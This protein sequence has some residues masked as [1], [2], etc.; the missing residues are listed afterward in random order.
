MRTKTNWLTVLPAENTRIIAGKWGS[1]GEGTSVSTRTRF[2]ETT[3]L[4]SLHLSP[5]LDTMPVRVL[6][7]CGFTQ[8]S[9]IYSKQVCITVILPDPAGVV[10]TNPFSFPSSARSARHV[11]TPSSSSSSLL[12]SSRRRT[13]HGPRLP[14]TSLRPTLPPRP[15]SKP[16]RQLR[17]LGGLLAATRAST[18]VSMPRYTVY[19]V[20]LTCTGFDET[21]TYIHDFMV[22]NGP[23]DGIMGFSQGACMASILAALVGYM[24]HALIDPSQLEQPGLHPNWPAEP[25]I[26]KFKCEQSHCGVVELT[27]SRHCR[28]WLPSSAQCAI[29]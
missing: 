9:T 23:F 3:I 5:H 8:N 18:R 4:L 29:V 26:P 19:A 2:D 21:L 16:P 10:L 17:V 25:A 7:L 14:W 1:E 27:C 22:K 11:R 28:R 24:L 15:S 20:Q 6:S 12:S 13:C